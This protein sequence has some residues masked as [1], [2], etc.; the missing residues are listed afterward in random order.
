MD[1][2]DFPRFVLAFLLVLGLIGLLA[3]FLRRYG[4]KTRA[5]L[6][7]KEMGHRLQVVETRYLDSKRRLVLVK[8]DNTEHLLLLGEGGNAV[9]E[10]DIPPQG[11]S[12]EK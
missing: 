7:V 4:E 12:G 10:S 1:T 5:L 9:V 8:R 11:E 6:G 3:F 2:V